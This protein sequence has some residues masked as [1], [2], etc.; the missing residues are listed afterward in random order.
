MKT[1]KQK[2]DKKSRDLSELFWIGRLL[3]IG[4]IIYSTYVIIA[5][6]Y[7]EVIPVV[8]VAPQAV[9]AALLVYRGK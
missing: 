5:G 2:K 9:Y 8:L 3:V 6:F 7:G 4:S 1:T